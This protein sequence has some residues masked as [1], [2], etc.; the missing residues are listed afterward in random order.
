MSILEG[1]YN[2]RRVFA[3]E[4][5]CVKR[6]R[7]Q[8]KG[9]IFA[10]HDIFS[11]SKY[12]DIQAFVKRLEGMGY[13]AVELIDTTDGKFIEKSEAGWMDLSGSALLVGVK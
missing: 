7:R 13:Q 12:G 11:K 6:M 9:G 5:H 10:I 2:G 3:D 1:W 8:K 4:S